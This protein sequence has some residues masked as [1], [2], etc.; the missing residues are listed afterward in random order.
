MILQLVLI[1]ISIRALKISSRRTMYSYKNISLI[2][3]IIF[4]SVCFITQL[5]DIVTW[6]SDI[7]FN[8]YPF[9]YSII[10][11]F[12]VFTKIVTF[13]IL[14]PFCLFLIISS[15]VLLK[16]EG[17]SLPNLLGIILCLV[18]LI[19]S[20]AIL[21]SYDIL[22]DFM[23]IHSYE[24]HCFSIWFETIFAIVI[25]YFECLLFATMFV[26]LKARYH[27]PKFDK[28]H[29]IILG[30]RMRDDGKP[31]GLLRERI[32]R[33]IEFSKLQ[34]KNA[35]KELVFV[36][37]GG[38]GADEPVTEAASMKNYL[39][40]KHISKTDIIIEDES[41]TTAENFRFS[42]QIIRSTKNIAF[43][44]SGY[45]VFRAGVI[46]ANA[47]FKDIEGIGSKFPWYYYDSATIR[48]FIANINSEK[49]M[50]LRNI[51]VIIISLTILIIIGYFMSIL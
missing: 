46:A 33:A 14:P 50:H 38:Q 36:P 8:I 29:I 30:C 39:L 19:G 34:K 3:G 51:A 26:S 11:S 1:V 2:G 17:K 4:F 44:T 15:I 41:K 37:S 20:A 42:K 31:A 24:G 47:G 22:T 27:V 49:Y 16:K 25:G 9:F 7:P 23:N 10:G 18:L 45:H 5:L 28:S 32:N 43:A 6:P 48:E 21:F 35:K 40:E 12:T 13:F